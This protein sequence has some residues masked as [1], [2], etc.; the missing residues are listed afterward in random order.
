MIVITVLVVVSVNSGTAAKLVAM[1]DTTVVDTVVLDG[2]LVNFGS[3]VVSNY[4]AARVLLT[5]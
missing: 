1:A 2:N 3:K 5:M 4:G